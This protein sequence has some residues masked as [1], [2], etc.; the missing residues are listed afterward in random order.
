M[1]V[2][3]SYYWCFT[4][5]GYRF[6]PP[7]DETVP[8]VDI[9]EFK[10]LI[11]QLEAGV[12]NTPHLQGYIEL[13]AKRTL[14]GVRRLIPDAHWEI[15]RGSR[16]SARDYCRKLAS[17][18][19][20]AVEFGTWVD[21]EQGR[22]TDIQTVFS[23]A[24]NGKS[25]L[26]IAEEV[27]G[28]WCKHHR[29]LQRY[30]FLRHKNAKGFRNVTVNVYVGPAGSGKT[31]KAY[32]ENPGLY[33]LEQGE[34]R[35]WFDGY[36]GETC[37]LLDDFYGWIKY[38]F[39]LNLLDGYPVRLPVKGGHTWAMWTKVIITS[40]KPPDS[41]YIAGLTP[42]LERRISSVITFQ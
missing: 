24:K 34:D 8:I 23:W 31:R 6:A 35:V 12:N 20:P 22:R 38:G 37:I 27:P 16:V 1:S 2:A 25:E 14:N 3:Q 15:R 30:Q 13:K 33:K 18:L 36:E 4:L 26:E 9:S 42:A 7:L 40:N 32:E 11:Y 19:S 5:N 29:A 10:Y 41:W 28:L 17:Q 39:L 21:G